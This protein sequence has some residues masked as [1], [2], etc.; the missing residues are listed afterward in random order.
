MIIVIILLQE[1]VTLK[2]VSDD[3]TIR[4]ELM[5]KIAFSI[6]SVW[7]KPNIQ[8]VNKKVVFRGDLGFG[9]TSNAIVGGFTPFNAKRILFS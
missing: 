7:P 1:L 5:L 8:I 9:H 6:T 4:H 3:N 2:M